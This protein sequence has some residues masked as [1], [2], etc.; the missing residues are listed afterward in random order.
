M[1]TDEIKTRKV[2]IVDDAPENIQV[3]M[4]TLKNDY[5]IVA[6]TN[7]EKA[8]SLASSEPAPD[9][10]LLDVMMPGMDGYEVCR[11]LKQ[12]E[13]TR[14]IPVVFITALSQKEDEEKGLDLGAVD[15]ITKPFSPPIVKARVK[16]HL[17]LK[18]HRDHLE[19][20]VRERTHELALTREVTI[21]SLATLAE[22][23]DPETG[24]HINRT[25]NYVKVL[26]EFL[27]NRNEF[28]EF[29]NNGVIELLYVSAPLHDIGKVGVKDHILL[30]PGPLTLDEFE[31]MKRH[32]IFGHEAIKRAEAK[33][34]DNSFLR[35]AGEI[36]YTHH[37]KWNGSGYPRGLRENMIPVSG[38]LM[39]I[40]DV[41]DALISKRVYKP[42]FPHS[43]AVKIIAEGKESHFDPVMV[44]AFLELS[45]RFRAIAIKFADHE[46][47][48]KTLTQ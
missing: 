16:N 8:L 13:K 45:E 24:G 32:T 39:A 34:G 35:Y 43:Q 27:K 10:I 23:R 40:A 15:Y 9:I 17:E 19:E 42:P 25:Q 46:E 20:L 48:L 5:K 22:Y 7:G 21:Q 30:K 6:A 12:G 28:N 3:L 41:Y 11:R 37:E 1:T 44:D 38:R 2:L 36:A 47:E 18:K 4:G 26:A 33:L 14:D 31:E 29:F